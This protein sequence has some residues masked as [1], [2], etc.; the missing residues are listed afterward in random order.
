M[1]RDAGAAA[2]SFE[3]TAIVNRAPNDNSVLSIPRKP[4]P[5]VAF[6]EPSS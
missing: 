1:I 2:A 6:F 5:L 4:M 3:E